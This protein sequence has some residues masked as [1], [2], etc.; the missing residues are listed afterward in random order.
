MDQTK[1]QNLQ[2]VTQYRK[3]EFPKK[4]TQLLLSVSVFS[5][6]VSNSTWLSFLF[7]GLNFPSFLFQLVTHTIGRSYIFL[8]CNG[9]LVFLARYPGLISSSSSG[10]DHADEYFF[11]KSGDGLPL[12]PDKESAA[13]M[14][15]TGPPESSTVVD[16]D[17]E[18]RDGKCFMEEETENLTEEEKKA[19][20]DDGTSVLEDEDPKEASLESKDPKE[21]EEDGEHWSLSNEELN[22]KFD[23]F[24]R[25]TKEEIRIGSMITTHSLVM[26]KESSSFD[27]SVY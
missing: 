24:I 27:Q 7:R 11:R 1:L 20:L 5:L 18:E 15:T 13:E 14:D 3:S 16:D 22:K 25:R 26:M 6:F 17:Q 8:L 2:A 21:E 4:L 23:D 9:I 19:I 10:F 12:L